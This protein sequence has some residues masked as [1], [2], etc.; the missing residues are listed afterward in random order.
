MLA[1]VFF[2]LL[3]TATSSTAPETREEQACAPPPANPFDPS[4]D[5]T[6]TQL[7]MIKAGPPPACMCRMGKP[8]DKGCIARGDPTDPQATQWMRGGLMRSQ[9]LEDKYVFRR[10]FSGGEE[11]SLMGHGVFV[12]LGAFTGVQLSNTYFFE[13]V[14]RWRG[15]LIEANENNYKQLR[16]TSMRTRASKL[17][18]AVCRNA[19]LLSMSG[20][21]GIAALKYSHSAGLASGSDMLVDALDLNAVPAG[22]VVCLPMA[23]LLRLAGLATDP[24]IHGIDFFSLDVEGA[25]EAVIET[26]DW[27]RLPVRVLLIELRS[28]RRRADWIHNALRAHGMCR[29]ASGIGLNNEVWVDPLFKVK[30]SSRRKQGWKGQGKGAGEE[31]QK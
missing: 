28:S 24:K 9:G 8:G 4:F 10:F 22:L 30:T 19:S 1:I 14:L 13:K 26:H 17:H 11:R 20:R 3:A 21:G 2:L 15:V 27:E 18:A 5:C 16:E 29:F 25:E 23:V 12:E 6:A 31:R 7:G